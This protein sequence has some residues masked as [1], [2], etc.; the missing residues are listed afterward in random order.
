MIISGEPDD[1]G[2]EQLSIPYESI[3]KLILFSL[4]NT[5]V[6]NSLITV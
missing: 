3:D 2:D 5:D 4:L 1:C 6:K